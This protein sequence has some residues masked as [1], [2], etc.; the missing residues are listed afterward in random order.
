MNDNFNKSEFWLERGLSNL[1]T[2]E[3]ITIRKYI[4][5]DRYIDREIALDNLFIII[6]LLDI[7]KIDYRLIF[8]A[9]LG[10][11]R[12]KEL[13]KWDSDIDLFVTDENFKKIND[14][15]F[16]EQVN[17]EGF[18]F[19]CEENKRKIKFFKNYEKIAIN[20]YRLKNSKY[21]RSNYNFPKSLLEEYTLLT[22]KNNQIKVP[23]SIENFLE[24]TYGKNWKKPIKSSDERDYMTSDVRSG[25]RLG[26]I[27]E[28]L[29]K[30]K[31]K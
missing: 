19:R 8:G 29:K 11:F 30:L 17:K 23:K 27:M 12:D 10:L 1:S 26:R 25:G 13:I 4:H 15:N 7:Y 3:W 20:S 2:D 6:K 22:V 16:L 5:K 21:I 9:L 24:F 28:I 14:I 18:I 31:I